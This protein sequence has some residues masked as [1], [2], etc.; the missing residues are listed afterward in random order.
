MKIICNLL[1]LSLSLLSAQADWLC[2]RGSAGNGSSDLSIPAKLKI[3][4]QKSWAQDI[5]GRGLSS[6]IVIGDTIYLTA[7]S[8][9]YQEDLH[10]LAYSSIDGLQQWQ[11]TFK[12]TGRTVCHKKT[13]VAASTLASD[14]KVII[15][16]FSSNDIFCL[17]LA[18]NLKWVRGLTFDHP[19]IANG[20]GMS[21]SPVIVNGVAI[22]QVEND[23]DSFTFGLDLTNGITVWK[24]QR[25]KSANW[26]SPVIMTKKGQ[27]LVGLQSKEGMTAIEPRTGETV[28]EYQEGAST[29]PSSA[30]AEQGIILV[31]SNGITA[32]QLD[33]NLQNFRQIWEDNKLKPGT[34]SP[35]CHRGSLYVINNANVLSCASVK[36]GKIKWR[37]RLKGP[38]SSSPLITEEHL[39][40]FSENGLGQVVNLLSEKPEVIH[41]VDLDA[42]ILCSPAI[43]QNAILVRSDNKLW[44]LSN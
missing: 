30:W 32:L 39:Y 20:L 8:G 41:T 17:D 19:N 40:V 15:A 26:T 44:K 34:G 36:T 6:P 14:E 9:P 22:A 42:T 27:A 23:A 35:S 38:I 25:P 33:D 31:P 7:S 3:T 5:P 11:R 10:I 29:I 13:C 21:S 28:W 4:G 12:A 24:K 16:Q 43:T 2:F 18:G 1:F 37:L